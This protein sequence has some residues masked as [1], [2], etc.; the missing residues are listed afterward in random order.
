MCQ[1]KPFSRLTAGAGNA[2]S[3]S[4]RYRKRTAK[5]HGR[6]PESPM[7]ARIRLKGLRRQL[8]DCEQ[9]NRQLRESLEHLRSSAAAEL[10]ETR[11]ELKRAKEADGCRKTV[12]DTRDPEHPAENRHTPESSEREGAPPEC[13]ASD[14]DTE[15][16]FPKPLPGIDAES[17]IAALCVTPDIFENI[18][19]LFY[20]NNKNL[21]GKIKRAYAEK[22]WWAV[23]ELAHGIKG[24][25]ANIRAMALS[26]SAQALENASH[27]AALDPLP[28]EPSEAMQQ[29][30]A[31]DLKRV[32]DA[33]QSAAKISSAPSLSEKSRHHGKP[34]PDIQ[35]DI[36]IDRSRLGTM[37]GDFIHVLDLAVPE[38][39][40]GHL[41]KVRP[42]LHDLDMEEI[43][44]CI[45]RYDYDE[46]QEH[47]KTLADEMDISFEI[48][49][50]DMSSLGR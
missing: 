35:P 39:I 46:A 50:P 3:G 40:R 33:I 2:A 29:R 5:K 36:Q 25:A 49:V 6:H 27:R 30:L 21:M 17:A 9:E 44:D 18:L 4:R 13:H 1:H 10:R 24:S 14:A 32:L 23:K 34:G 26:E 48:A 37:L 15:G 8:R 47:V 16:R 38:D 7:A 28:T 20:K 42:H 45:C 19:K 22:D 31:T 43:E 12:A 11:E 41:E